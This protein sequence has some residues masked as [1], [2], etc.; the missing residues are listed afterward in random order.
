MGTLQLVG[1]P[2]AAIALIKAKGLSGS[3]E[4][5]QELCRRYSCN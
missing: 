5:Q 3:T 2:E 4:E 1:S